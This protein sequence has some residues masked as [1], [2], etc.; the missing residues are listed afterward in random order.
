MDESKAAESR[1]REAL[2]YPAHEAIGESIGASRETVSRL[3]ADFKR[4]GMIR[5]RGGALVILHPEELR[6]L[7]AS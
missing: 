7:G 1:E 2:R 3:L 4:H 6:S 5:V